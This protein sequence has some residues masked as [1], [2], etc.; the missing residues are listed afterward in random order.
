MDNNTIQ[1]FTQNMT[2]DQ[3][4]GILI[5]SVNI[6]QQ[7]GAYSLRDASIIHKAIEV[8]NVNASEETASTDI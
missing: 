4:I 3:A 7:K 8:L 2:S 1:Q 5:Q 6:A